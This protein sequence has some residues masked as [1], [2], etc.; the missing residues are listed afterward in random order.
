[1]SNNKKFVVEAN[2]IEEAM[3]LNLSLSEFLLL[4]Y[5]E[6]AD[7]MTFDLEKI[8]SKLKVDVNLILEAFN[9]LISKNIIN[10]ETDKDLTGKRYDKVSIAKFYQKLEEENKKQEKAKIKDDI[11]TKF[12]SEFQRP[13]TGT[14][15][16]IIKAWLEKMYSEELI[17]KALE[18]AVYNGATSIRYIDTILYEWNKKGFKTKED[19]DNYLKNRY[20]NKKLEESFILD[21][22]W[23]DEDE[24]K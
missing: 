4:L 15:F 21:Y 18:E 13:L 17:L 7:D 22:N 24:N 9:N 23:L 20:E 16:E 6:N 2:F 14:E 12:E 5:F 1:M 19:V 10:L 8:S 11:F 3:R